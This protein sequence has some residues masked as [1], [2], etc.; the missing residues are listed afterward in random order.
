MMQQRT[1]DDRAGMKRG[2]KALVPLLAIVA[3][4]S[5]AVA[6]V[7]I[8]LQIEERDRRMA[9]ER[10]L[11]I[12]LGERDDLKIQVAEV[13]GARTRLEQD[14][15]SVRRELRSIEDQLTEVSI[16]KETLAK[17]VDERQDEIER[18]TKDVEQLRGDRKGLTSELAEMKGQE[19]ILQAKVKDL[20]A[21]KSALETKVMEL[22]QQPTV[23]LD[24]IVVSS[25]GGGE[26]I[27][28]VSLSSPSADAGAPRGSQEGQV[29][30][31]N[32][33]YDF[34][35][36][37]LGRNQGVA[38]GQELQV[39]R[40]TEVLGRVKIE[41]VYDELSAAAI[42]PNSEKD[43]MHEGDVVRAL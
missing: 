34:V 24:K 23:E 43:R 39:V 11:L 1:A 31:V 10:E 32:R 3:I 6:G 8:Y 12:V 18:L 21:A 15:T 19:E 25:P 33:E 5:M 16:A 30:V 36:M 2:G 28:P 26:P 17:S 22:T 29:V 42:M 4:L 41:K 13:E 38:I 40:G 37:N 9:K 14:L 20:E 7:A 27:V 35:V